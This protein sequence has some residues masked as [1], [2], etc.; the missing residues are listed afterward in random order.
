MTQLFALLTDFGLQDP[1]VG[2]M[3]SV[4]LQGYG[5]CSFL[6][7]SHQVRAHNIRQGA[8]FLA[9]TWPYLPE[10]TICLAVVD[11]GVGTKRPILLMAKDSKYLLAPDNGLSSLLC[12]LPG[13]MQFWHLSPGQFLENCSPT[14][15]GR[16][17]FAPMAVRLAQGN[18]FQSLTKAITSETIV[19][20]PKSEPGLSNK[21]LEAVVIHID[22]FGNCVLNIAIADWAKTM[23]QMSDFECLYPRSGRVFVRSNYADIPASGLGIIP[24]SQGFYELAGNQDSCADRL[25][26]EIG[27]ACLFQL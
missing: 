2:Q 15:H 4:I 6:D 11:P 25:G 7:I 5:Q 27:D 8:F 3:K 24:G 14:F 18:L 26:L 19:Q 9:A 10:R 16:D 1:Y 12:Q 13:K 22:R 21:R 23:E 17:I 20:L